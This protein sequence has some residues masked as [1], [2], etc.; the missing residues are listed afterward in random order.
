MAGAVQADADA[1]IHAHAPVVDQPVAAAAAHDGSARDHLDDRKPSLAHSMR[2]VTTVL[3]EDYE[4]R[5]TEEEF[6]TLRRVSGKIM[7]S[8][9][10]IAF[11]ELCERFSYYGSSVLYT[12]FINRP[13]PAGSTTGAPVHAGDLPGALGMGTKA[14]QGISLFNMFFA[15]L[16][17]LVG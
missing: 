2:D 3:D 15:Y 14:A 10:T 16:M 5:P 1:I 7:W 11:V 8:M 13:L 17:P 9:W 4:G 6:R 12:N